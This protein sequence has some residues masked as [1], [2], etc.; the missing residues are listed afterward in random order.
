MNCGQ[1]PKRI[2]NHFNGMIYSTDSS[3]TNAHSCCCC[4]CCSGLQDRSA[5]E[6]GREIEAL[7]LHGGSA[8]SSYRDARSLIAALLHARSRLS[9]FQALPS[10]RT[11]LGY[12]CL[13]PT[14][15]SLL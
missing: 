14:L 4:S 15:S 5:T 3:A 13:L 2:E 9:P 1:P 12:P 11:A 6:D 10:T 8:G 7:S